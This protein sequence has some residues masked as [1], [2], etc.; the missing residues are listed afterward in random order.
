MEKESKVMTETEIEAQVKR[1][2]G[3]VLKK[4]LSRE[5]L[6]AEYRKYDS[7]YHACVLDGGNTSG[8][9]I[10]REVYRRLLD[11]DGS[12]ADDSDGKASCEA[13]SYTGC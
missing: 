13:E 8:P 4:K 9:Y 11:E 2:M 3:I 12:E 1:E 7:I 6:E 10:W 5:K